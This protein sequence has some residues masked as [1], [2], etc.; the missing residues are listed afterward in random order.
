VTDFGAGQWSIPRGIAVNG[1]AAEVFVADTGRQQIM[2]VDSTGQVTVVAGMAAAGATGTGFGAP[3]FSG[4]GGAATSAQLNFPWD[5]AVGPA[6]VLYVADLENNL[7]RSLTPQTT[8][9]QATGIQV[10]NG[11]SLAPGPV[12]PGMLLEVRGTGIPAVEAASSPCL[13]TLSDKTV[14]A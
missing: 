11:V 4:D 2:R 12:A 6:G 14:W 13:K 5:V 9:V 10:L 1:G 7:V 8:A 3:G